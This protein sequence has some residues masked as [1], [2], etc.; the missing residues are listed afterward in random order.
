MFTRLFRSTSAPHTAPQNAK[1]APHPLVI[2][3]TLIFTLDGDAVLASVRRARLHRRLGGQ[4]GH[5]ARPVG[6]EHTHGQDGG[7]PALRRPA[8]VLRDRP[9]DARARRHPGPRLPA[10]AAAEARARPCGI[11]VGSRQDQKVGGYGGAS[12]HARVNI[13][14]GKG[15]NV[16]NITHGVVWGVWGV[17]LGR[18]N[19]SNV[20]MHITVRSLARSPVL[21]RSRKQSKVV[22]ATDQG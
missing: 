13:V 15:R 17:D 19:L 3:F 16:P 8:R 4:G 20:R 18:W 10:H 22:W 7:E 11:S 2:P 6:R 5:L 14:R 1:K 9:A 12:A 21:D